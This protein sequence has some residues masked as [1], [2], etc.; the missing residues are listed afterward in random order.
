MM[1][2]RDPRDVPSRVS[3]ADEDDPKITPDA[4]AAPHRRP[5][6]IDTILRT[7][8]E[9][10]RLGEDVARAGDRLRL[11]LDETQWL[12]FLAYEE[13]ANARAVAAQD[14]VARAVLRS[15]GIGGAS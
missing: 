14:A 11:A 2:R 7:D 9:I 8:P 1:D 15:C 13:A 10:L 3:S 6:L 4:W 12:L 5:W